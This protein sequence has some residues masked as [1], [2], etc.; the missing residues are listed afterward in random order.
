L[1]PNAVIVSWWN[2][3]TALWY[4]QKVEGLRPD[5]FVVDDRTMLDL[6]LGGATDVIGR[7]LGQ[8]PV[9]VIRAN[10]Y[11]LGLVLDQYRLSPILGDG[12]NAVYEVDG[13]IASP[14]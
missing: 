1:P 5:V 12:A 11:D 10:P 8:R 6:H 14:G 9:Y 7:Y 4:A 13:R 3:S 2:T